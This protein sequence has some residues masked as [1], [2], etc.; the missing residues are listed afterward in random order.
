MVIVLKRVQ[1]LAFLVS[2]PANEQSAR[3]SNTLI[4]CIEFIKYLN[5]RKMVR[6]LVVNVGQVKLFS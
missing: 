1:H 4:D 5:G 6:S 2:N 3:Q